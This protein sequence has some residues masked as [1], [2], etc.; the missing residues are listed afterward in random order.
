VKEWPIGEN[1]S[2]VT[3]GPITAGDSYDDGGKTLQPNNDLPLMNDTPYAKVWHPVAG[4]PTLGTDTG[5][6]L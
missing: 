2:G 5:F 4:T 6:T 3:Q 1:P